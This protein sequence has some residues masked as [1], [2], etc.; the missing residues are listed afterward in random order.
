MSKDEDLKTARDMA[1]KIRHDESI[2]GASADYEG[3]VEFFRI[4]L[5]KARLEER[6]RSEKNNRGFAFPG[7][8]MNEGMTIRQWLAGLAMQAQVAS[9]P[10]DCKVNGFYIPDH[11]YAQIAM[12]ANQIADAMIKQV[13]ANESK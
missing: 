11:D 1:D 2:G 12:M 4:M 6:N 9:Y 7:Y 13:E 8:G 3:R 10:Q 5:S